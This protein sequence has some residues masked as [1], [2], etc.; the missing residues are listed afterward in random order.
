MGE[1]KCY[2]TVDTLIHSLEEHGE[3]EI[4]TIIL[5][6]GSKNDP[7]F[8]KHNEVNSKKMSRLREGTENLSS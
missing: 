7:L 1:N 3:R 5:C 6:V 2:E 4:E 8:L